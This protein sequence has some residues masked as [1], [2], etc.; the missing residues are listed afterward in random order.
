MRAWR[1][2]GPSRGASGSGK[3]CLLP[4]PASWARE[5]VGVS[6][7]KHTVLLRR[8]GAF[9]GREDRGWSSYPRRSGCRKDTAVSRCLR[10]RGS[11]GNG[12]KTAFHG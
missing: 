1:G 7:Q 5:G 9:D 2:V 11:G 12:R 10:P 8:P 4:V 6:A 3:R